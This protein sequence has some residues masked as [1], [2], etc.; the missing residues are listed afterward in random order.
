MLRLV[1][2]LALSIPLLG[3]DAKNNPPGSQ[4]GPG[5]GGGGGGGGAQ[6]TALIHK[7]HV[8][9]NRFEGIGNAN[10]CQFDTNCFRG[11]CSQEVCSAEQ[12][13]NTTCDA[14]TVQI[15]ASA[16]CGCV[17]N[18][19][20]WFSTDGSTLPPA[21]AGS[22]GSG[23]GDPVKP[24]PDG[25][26]CGNKTC[27]SGEKCIEY[28]GIAGPAGPKFRECGIPCHPQKG[29]CPEGMTCT[30]IADGPGPVCRRKA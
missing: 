15:P 12:G 26:M 23:G 27:D 29:N 2:A 3:C 18:Q 24:P 25:A 4:S 17:A 5:G 11:G 21:T 1:L 8:L 13:V 16:S 30:T 10:A 7:D 9:Y 20:T 14:L 28:Y 19:C 22:G 6:R